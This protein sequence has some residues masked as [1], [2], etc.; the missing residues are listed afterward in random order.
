[1]DLLLCG[2]DDLSSLRYLA[3]K[4]Y[5]ETFAK[6]NTP[7][8][9]AAYLA[10]AFAPKKMAGEIADA[11]STFYLAMENGEAV[12]YLKLNEAAAQ[13]ELRDGASL[14][15]ERIYVLREFHGTGCGGRLLEKAIA[16]AEERGKEYAWLGVWERNERALRFYGKHGFRRFGE[17]IFQLGADKQLDYLLRRDLRPS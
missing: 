10:D 14:E 16:C 17:H 9:I 6:D 1:M 15:I 13:T 5:Q 11:A 3:I 8:D 7:D 2:P 12:G 4:T